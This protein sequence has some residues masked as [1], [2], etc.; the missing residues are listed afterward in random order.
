LYAFAPNF[1]ASYVGTPDMYALGELG[2][3]WFLAAL[4]AGAAGPI[5]YVTQT[6]D[7][8]RY[9]RPDVSKLSLT[10]S[11]FVSMLV[12]LTIPTI[13]GAF[14]AVAA[15]DENSLAAGFVAQAP[16]Y[17]LAPLVAI[18]IVGSLG[19]GGI[20]LYSMGLD[21][22]AI[23]PRLS[24]V[25]STSIVAAFSTVLVFLGKFVFDAEEAV[26][27][28]TLFITCLATSWI[29]VSMIGYFRSRGRFHKEDLQVFNS[30]KTGGRYW[31]T[32]G[33]NL[34][35]IAAWAV[36]SI[37]GIFAIS[38]VGYTGPISEYFNGVDLS[39]PTAGI[40]G[41]LLYLLLAG[42]PDHH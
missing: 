32:G 6:G 7:W 9:V 24:R 37:A 34:K 25:Q 36:G 38:S 3:T 21:M 10:I 30:G 29:S 4:T 12:G 41:G 16:M 22:D 8:A 14:I 18:A 28:A 2:P 13:F 1:D 39:I 19:Q 11:T 42:K 23:L 33:W 40:V 35:A 27:N 5:S 26:T 17:L 31:F 15:F 20:N